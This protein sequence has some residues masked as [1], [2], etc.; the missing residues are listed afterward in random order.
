[1]ESQTPG[2]FIGCVDVA[3]GDMVQGGFGSAGLTALESF[4]N[5]KD[6]TIL[7]CGRF[8]SV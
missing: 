7:R 4:S 8:D 5:L 2:G 1:M 3:L 6:S